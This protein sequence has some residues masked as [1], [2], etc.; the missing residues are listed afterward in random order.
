MKPVLIA[1]T[2]LGVKYTRIVYPDFIIRS[3]DDDPSIAIHHIIYSISS[4]NTIPADM[5]G[6]MT[7][8]QGTLQEESYGMILLSDRV[9][10]LALDCY[11]KCLKVRSDWATVPGV[12]DLLWRL[13][14]A[15]NDEL[16]FA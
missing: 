11:Y 13:L 9:G 15:I 16:F 10:R 8:S 1:R 2:L 12:D 3:I 6:L 5:E 7:C 14:E 4:M